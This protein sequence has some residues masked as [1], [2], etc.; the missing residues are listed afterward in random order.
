M[1]FK[2]S[3][4]PKAMTAIDIP[5]VVD[6]DGT[7]IKTDSLF[8]AAN[9]Y[10]ILNPLHLLKMI[11]WIPQGK[12]RF[13]ELLFSH[14]EINPDSYP[15]N[16]A[17]ITWLEEEKKRGRKIILAT[18]SHKI[19]AIKISDH[20]GLFDDVIA[21]DGNINLKAEHK[22]D[23]LVNRFGQQGFDYIG[24][25]SSDIPIWK[26]ARKAYVAS[27]S[28]KFID[29][30]KVIGN[31]ETVFP[32]K[33]TVGRF[34][35]LLSALRLHQW[36]KNLLIFIPLLAAQ[37]ITNI[38]AILDCLLAFF[39]FSLTA[40]SVYILNDLVDVRNDRHHQNKRKRPFAAGDLSL[41]IGWML[42]PGLIL[43]SFLLASM[44]LP[45]DF[46][47][48][49]AAY[50]IATLA[51]SLKLKQVAM[52]D[53]LILAALYTTR[54][55][56]G[57]TAINIP[58]SFWLLAFSLFI[59]LSLAFVKRF[60]ELKGVMGNGQH[61]KIRG[62]GYSTADLE[63][64]SS[65]GIT[66]GYI[67]VLVLALYVQDNHTIQLYSKPQL[68]WFAC[69]ILMY[70]ISRIWMTAHRGK[71]HEDPILFA[72]KDKISWIAIGGI[73]ITFLLAKIS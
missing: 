20:I 44:M 34:P 50:F 45:A 26:S 17:L 43:S 54:V 37:Q 10:L 4:N 40:S 14:S 27:S 70:W 31:L 51:Y 16:P 59:F 36:I 52:L 62:R 18:A 30:V 6:L 53:V 42:W 49:L 19:C 2:C 29:R 47:L 61:V 41:L 63:L 73:L 67:S 15:T 22:R 56:A 35:P 3:S 23:A 8:E 33:R 39:I 58:V 28:P 32:T 60:S 57:G 11:S 9:A 7:L 55:I 65:M 13:K 5:L 64:V 46:V 66:S 48:T 38:Q 12:A 25:H 68:I 21:T 24:N 1:G 71:M 69:P 72:I